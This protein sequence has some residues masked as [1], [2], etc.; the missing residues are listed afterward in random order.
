MYNIHGFTTTMQDI[1]DTVGKYLPEAQIDFDWD[2]N[3]A[4]K[5]ANAD[6]NYEMDNTSIREDTGWQPRY[7][8]DETI[9]DF[10][11]EAKAGR[12]G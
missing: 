11:S 6:N 12:A 2:R 4:M 8:L 3:E 1:V 7:L 9:L 10:I 5:I